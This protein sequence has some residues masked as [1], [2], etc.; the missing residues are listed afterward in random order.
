MLKYVVGSSLKYRFIVVFLAVGM[1]VIGVTQLRHAPVDVFPE[2]APPRVEVQTPALGLSASEVESLVTV[3]LEHSLN[4]IPGL[5]VIRSRSIEQLSV[6]ELI[7]EQGSDLFTARQLVQER[8]SA[9]IPTLPSWASPPFMIQPLSA[10]SRTIKIGLASDRYDLMDLSMIAYWKIR[11]RL[12]RVPGVANVPIWGERLKMLQVQVDP[13]TL[14]AA[15]VTLDDVFNTTSDSLDAGLLQFSTG[16]FIGAGGWVESNAA[17]VSLEHRLPIIE[18]P[19]LA[20]IPIH[21]SDGTTVLALGD[22]ADLVTDHQLLIGDA[23]I[24][25]GPGLMLIVEKLPWANTL[26][27]TRGVEEALAELEPA[28]EG[29]EIDAEIFRPATFIEQSIRNLTTSIFIGAMLMIFMLALFLF[30]WRTALISVVAIPLSLVGAGLVLYAMGATI[31]T[32]ILAGFVI[33]LG[34]IVDDAI[35]DIENVVRRLRE[36][37]AKGGTRSAA[38]VVLDASLEVRSAIVYAT[39]I[40]VAAIIPIFMLG[41]LSGSFFR[42][43]AVAYS[44]ALL[45]SMVVA[46]TVTPAL[47]L[48]F[49]KKEDSSTAPW[50]GRGEGCAGRA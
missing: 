9:I 49:F 21:T 2:F 45:A 24:N 34:D 6:I 7:F 5:D 35:I 44:L 32:M 23:V 43:L 19:D 3:P 20:S 25:D 37:R 30:E 42:P 17:R 38:K 12:L 1:M 46:L 36:D 47:S 31:N 4:G 27:V 50:Y 26:D 29:I 28:L 15:G 16:S 10:T 39:L 13:E 11:A 22:V 41:G 33:A 18:P 40:E 48:I 8:I 14:H